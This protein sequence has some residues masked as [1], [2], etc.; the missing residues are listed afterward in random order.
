MIK[1]MITVFDLISEHALISGHPPLKKK[2][3]IIIYVP[4]RWGSTY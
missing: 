2:K 3:K 4:W 1:G